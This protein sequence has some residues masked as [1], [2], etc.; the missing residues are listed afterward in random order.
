MPNTGNFDEMSDAAL[1][2]M[3]AQ[4]HNLHNAKRRKD[5]IIEQLLLIQ[6]GIG[7]ILKHINNA[8]ITHDDYLQ[9]V[10]KDSI[11]MSQELFKTVELIKRNEPY[12]A[13]KELQGILK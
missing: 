12:V 5:R 10:Q 3:A 7:N 6:E 11:A 8:A 4:K 2:Y 9:Y 1:Y 13:V